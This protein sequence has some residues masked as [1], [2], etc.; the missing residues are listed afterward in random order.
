M[1]TEAAAIALGESGY[2][3]DYGPQ[4]LAGGAHYLT[5]TTKGREAVNEYRKSLP[6]PPKPEPPSRSQLRYQE[7]L[8][9]RDAYGC[10]FREFFSMK[11][12]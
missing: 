3:H 9:A 7:F 5:L 10:T 6:Q 2:L 12:P 4:R 8:S 11:K 1:S